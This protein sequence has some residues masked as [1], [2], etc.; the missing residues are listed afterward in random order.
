LQLARLV[1]TPKNCIFVE[2]MMA[3]ARRLFIK[4]YDPF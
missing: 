4:D 3:A 1:M 2:C